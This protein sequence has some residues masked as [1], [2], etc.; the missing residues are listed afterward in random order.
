MLAP[1][2]D[3]IHACGERG[4]GPPLTPIAVGLMLRGG[5]VQSSHADDESEGTVAWVGLGGR[6]LEVEL[7]P[8]GGL[9]QSSHAEARRARPASRPISEAG[10]SRAFPFPGSLRR[11][12]SETGSSRGGRVQTSNADAESEEGLAGGGGRRL[13]EAG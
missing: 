13:L 2:L 9:V 7:V 8:R 5:P 12:V 4:G 10:S 3:T 11:P 6:L 1:G